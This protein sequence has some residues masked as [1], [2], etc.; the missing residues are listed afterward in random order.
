ML[1]SAIVLC[2][3]LILN[4]FI[5]KEIYNGF[6]VVDDIVDCSKELR[7]DDYSDIDHSIYKGCDFA[8]YDENNKVIYTTDK[9]LSSSINSTDIWMIN[10][11]DY[12][13]YYETY[14]QED[15]NGEISYVILQI[16]YI[17]DNEADRINNYCVLNSDL[18]VIQGELFAQL[19][20]LDQNEL[21]LLQGIYSDK[22][23]ISKY[24]FNNKKGQKRTIVFISPM[25]T[26]DS[27]NDI[28]DNANRIWLLA[29][30]VLAMVIG[31]QAFLFDRRIKSSIKPLNDA[32][33]SY[34]SG[35]KLDIDENTLPREFKNIIDNFNILID[36]LEKA[37]I[38]K[39]NA[40]KEKMKVIADISHDLKT[41]LTVIQGYA[42][43]FADNMIPEEKK[44]KYI[45]AILN[46]TQY[47]S[48][49]I[50][51]LF[52]YTRMNHPNYNINLDVKDI[53]ELSKEYLAE[54][55]PEIEMKGCKLEVD[56]PDTVINASVDVRL[57]RR[58]YDNLI[59]NI[60]KHNPPGTKI[61]F[62]I[63]RNQEI[64]RI[65][66][67]DSGIGVP[68][69]IKDNI[70][71]PFVTSNIARTSGSGTGLGMSISKKIVD[72]HEGSIS[73]VR[74]P[75]K[76]YNTEILITIPMKP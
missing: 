73:L 16:K 51:E 5:N 34:G 10:T 26:E 27:Y 47:T 76:N 55:Y 35:S 74:T 52:L 32:I 65:T 30:P 38:Q 70:F 24:E 60:L 75:R 71:D 66:F 41:P 58:L 8:V 15:E 48:N 44:Q 21:E 50:D 42:N 43:A 62:A 33:V 14:E 9:E 39:D 3:Y 1:Y 37:N 31:L 29:V 63:S 23:D 18:E 53:C 11:Y 68:D 12:S 72:I 4:Y 19:G 22:K 67:A 64:I 20:K 69:D 45:S 28:V 59:D 6:P 2:L 36:K 7:N 56:I 40:N 54:K 57:I 46:K 13:M 17:E 25:F 61:L 49:M